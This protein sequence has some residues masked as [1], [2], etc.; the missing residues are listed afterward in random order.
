VKLQSKESKY[1][2]DKYIKFLPWIKK[3]VWVFADGIFTIPFMTNKVD[4]GYGRVFQTSLWSPLILIRL[5]GSQD[6]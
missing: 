1:K 6:Q 3:I 2:M 5:D 4:I